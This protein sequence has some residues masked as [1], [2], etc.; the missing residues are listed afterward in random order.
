VLSKINENEVIEGITFYLRDGVTKEIS[1]GHIITKVSLS[2]EL[3]QISSPGLLVESIFQQIQVLHSI[4]DTERRHDV[5]LIDAF[6]DVWE[7]KRMGG[8]VSRLTGRKH[9]GRGKGGD[10]EEE[11][12][13]REEVTER[14]QYGI[15][16]QNYK[17]WLNSVSASGLENDHEDPKYIRLL[18]KEKFLKFSL[19]IDCIFDLQTLV[20]ESNLFYEKEGKWKA[21]PTSQF[22][23]SY[24]Q[25]QQRRGSLER[26]LL[27]NWDQSDQ[28]FEI[29]EFS[30]SPDFTFFSHR[31]TPTAPLGLDGEMIIYLAHCKHRYIWFDAGCFP[32]I[33][34]DEMKSI[35]ASELQKLWWHRHRFCRRASSFQGYYLTDGLVQSHVVQSVQEKNSPR[36]LLPTKGFLS[37]CNLLETN[38][39]KSISDVTSPGIDYALLRSEIEG[40]NT[41]EKNTL[42]CLFDDLLTPHLQK[43][44]SSGPFLP[45]LTSKSPLSLLPPTPLKQSVDGTFLHDETAIQ[46]LTSQLYSQKFL[47]A[48]FTAETFYCRDPMTGR[49]IPGLALPQLQQLAPLPSLV[50]PLSPSNSPLVSYGW[51][52]F[53]ESEIWL[54]NLEWKQRDGERQTLASGERTG[55][56]F[57]HLHHKCLISCRE[58]VVMFN[59][60]K[61]QTRSFSTLSPDDI[62]PH[63]TPTD[64]LLSLCSPLPC[65]IC[66]RLTNVSTS[67]AQPSIA[68][69]WICSACHC[70]NDGN[71]S[72]C[73]QCHQEEEGRG[74]I[75]ESLVENTDYQLGDRV[76]I[77]SRDT[78]S[79]IGYISHVY[80]CDM[81]DVMFLDKVEKYVDKSCLLREGKRRG[82]KIGESKR[83]VNS[84]KSSSSGP[85][86]LY[87]PCGVCSYLNFSTDENCKLCSLQLGKIPPEKSSSEC[88]FPV[89]TQ[90]LVQ[91]LHPLTE[92]PSQRIHEDKKNNHHKEEEQ[93]QEE[94]PPSH[95]VTYEPAVVKQIHRYGLYS[96]E[97]EKSGRVLRYVPEEMVSELGPASE[98][99]WKCPSCGHPNQSYFSLETTKENSSSS[100]AL[101]CSKCGILKPAV[102]HQRHFAYLENASMML[103]AKIEAKYRGGEIYYPGVISRITK[104][105]LYEV[106][107]DHG[108]VETDVR[109]EDL[110]VIAIYCGPF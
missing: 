57:L 9:E 28:F 107:Y 91:I 61:A 18:N 33:Q 29:F 87:R 63:N 12:N 23:E 43:S 94:D 6:R 102:S 92:S 71:V 34:E 17:Q 76:H 25:L 5:F 55:D 46:P 51:T 65:V 95:G 101:K 20:M 69:D 14:I 83:V 15:H 106:E 93:K 100:N 70:V 97:L 16:Y 10:E 40:C 66:R 30:E 42:L 4:P 39:K 41:S 59:P 32:S 73:V 49:L 26:I 47:P 103:G 108:E 86:L 89:G 109:E 77:Q 90:V 27:W 75:D 8:I 67:S 44:A 82:G 45:F 52:F 58:R 84:H 80:R 72:Q 64:S 22:W 13:I 38:L 35:T 2:Y 85:T 56:L 54:L 79:P 105:G 21:R 50:S 88:L 36:D 24:S 19:V 110:I 74:A 98:I 78:L 11:E 99:S 60:L 48:I 3:Q 37:L 62:H 31:F 104:D 68:S 1:T 96:V 7:W 53:Q 81:Y